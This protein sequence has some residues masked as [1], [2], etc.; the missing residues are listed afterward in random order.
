MFGFQSKQAKDRSI[1][2]SNASSV[3]ESNISWI[4]LW[5]DWVFVRSWFLN[6]DERVCS[7]CHWRESI[8][9]INTDNRLN[10]V[11]RM[12]GLRNKQFLSTAFV[13][14]SKRA[15][16]QS[17]IYNYAKLRFSSGN[18]FCNFSGVNSKSFYI[19]LCLIQACLLPS[20]A[21]ELIRT[22]LERN[23]IA[24][25]L[26]PPPPVEYAEADIAECKIV[27]YFNKKRRR[28]TNYRIIKLLP[29]F[30]TDVQER[31]YTFRFN[32]R[33]M[34]FALNFSFTARTWWN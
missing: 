10:G 25:K 31:H 32:S 3:C 27:F 18:T 5:I 17:D 12:A 16:F 21:I 20:R 28:K 30:K 11:H 2:R 1:F 13:W 24:G 7:Q 14:K 23:G 29:L 15:R 34:N 9:I 26:N 33:E 4:C 6:R 22:C 19:F 8:P